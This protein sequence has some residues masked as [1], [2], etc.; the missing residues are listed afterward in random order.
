MMNN[1]ENNK[2]LVFEAMAWCSNLHSVREVDETYL[3]LNELVN[4]EK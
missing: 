2:I 3:L 4:C 1:Q